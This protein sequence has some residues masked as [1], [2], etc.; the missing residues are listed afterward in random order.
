MLEPGRRDQGRVELAHVLRGL[1]KAAGLSGQRLAARCAMSQSKI[2]RIESGKL[3][4]T[5]VDVE[6][7]LNALEVPPDRA[8]DLLSLARAA[9]ID[10]ASWRSYA[11]AGLWRRQAELQA[12]AESSSEVRQFLP[13]IPS[14]LI[15]TAEYAEAVMT[16]AVGR[17]YSAGDRAKAVA[18]RMNSQRVLDHQER[19]FVFL[20][21]E[22][23]V[24]WQR[25]EPS[26]MVRQLRHMVEVAGRPNVDL[27]IVPSGVT[28]SASPL[29]VFVVYDQR[30][31]I[32]ELFSGEVALRD[33]RDVSYHRELF[34]FFRRHALDGD[35]ARNLLISVAD[36]F[37]RLPE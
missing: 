29:N 18:A 34:E 16:H 31:V 14:G 32:V 17:H 1:R 22:Q 36:D 5:V 10:Y 27:A 33:P 19:R 30:L 24:R 3:L 35:D 4:P 21:T 25:A 20:L 23:A 28:V 13:A 7:I 11:R 2:S 15:Q 12:L 37:M 6:R 26:V 8:H 9:N